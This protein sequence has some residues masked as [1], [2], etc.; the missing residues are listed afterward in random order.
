MGSGDKQQQIIASFVNAVLIE[1]MLDHGAEL[2]VLWGP[3]V[4]VALLIAIG[5]VVW[6]VRAVDRDFK[7]R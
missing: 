1:R 3:K 6:A 2:I 4:L 5:V 7:Q